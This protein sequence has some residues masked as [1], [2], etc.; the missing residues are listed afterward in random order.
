MPF[1]RRIRLCLMVALMMVVSCT[2]LISEC[3]TES[4]L[5]G[6]TNIIAHVHI[7]SV[8]LCAQYFRVDH[9]RCN[10]CHHHSAVS[11]AAIRSIVLVAQLPFA[12]L[13]M[14]TNAPVIVEPE[15]VVP[16]GS[17]GRS[18]SPPA[19]ASSPYVDGAGDSAMQLANLPE[20]GPNMYT[21][22]YGPESAPRGRLFAG[23][24]HTVWDPRG[25]G[26][27]TVRTG[28]T[29]GAAGTVV[30]S[31]EAVPGGTTP[32]G[33]GA[34]NQ[35]GDDEA[36]GDG[37]GAGSSGG[38]GNSS[39]GGGPPAWDPDACSLREFP[40]STPVTVRFAE[41]VHWRQRVVYCRSDATVDQ[42]KWAM[43]DIVGQ[44]VSTYRISDGF[45]GHP[46]ARHWFITGQVA[47]TWQNFQEPRRV[48]V[49]V[50]SFM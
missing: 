42:V 4:H 39:G 17:H 3:D 1:S 6:S 15:V 13:A 10:C 27:F 19:A 14:A 25:G 32:T 36:A 22:H 16:Q 37:A 40:G 44:N 23:R 45:S 50:P 26:A 30:V 48:L 49:V 38:G 24:G 43:K 11:T 46:L 47:N 8:G 7:R 41:V 28:I 12:G 9:G 34:G 33:A 31:P 35:P 18:R 20:Q 2:G 29:G 21:Y 5:K